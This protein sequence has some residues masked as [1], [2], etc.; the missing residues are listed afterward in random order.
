[1]CFAAGSMHFGSHGGS[2]SLGKV[3]KKGNDALGGRAK[4]VS[5]ENFSLKLGARNPCVTDERQAFASANGYAL[6]AEPWRVRTEHSLGSTMK[7]IQ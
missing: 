4:K 1:M 2:G 3:P 6:F 7:L 5:R